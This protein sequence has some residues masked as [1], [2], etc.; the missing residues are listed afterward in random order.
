MTQGSRWLPRRQ[1]FFQRVKMVKTCLVEDE[2]LVLLS[3]VRGK[4]K[5]EKNGGS[6]KVRWFRDPYVPSGL[7]VKGPWGSKY[8]QMYPNICQN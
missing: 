5:S 3:W 7:E 1:I 4:S 8:L 2:T 6:Q